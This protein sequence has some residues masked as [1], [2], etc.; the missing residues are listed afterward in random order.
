VSALTY[1][2]PCHAAAHGGAPQYRR[3]APA[4]RIVTQAGPGALLLAAWSSFAMACGYRPAA[5]VVGRRSLCVEGLAPHV[6]D[7]D[8]AAALEAGARQVLAGEGR[9]D[10]CEATLVLELV[11]L[12][13]V[14]EGLVS[15]R[16]D[17]LSRAARWTATA[18]GELHARGR[19]MSSEDLG[20]IRVGVTQAYA[21]TPAAQ[22]DA[23]SSARVEAARR[24]GEGLARRALGLP[25]PSDPR[26]LTLGDP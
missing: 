16:G 7:P 9:N 12:R 4:S 14:P 19:Q 17:V 3:G 26:P 10:A 21:S 13:S 11:E 5:D 1:C 24:A 15:R 8:A 2:R 6:S 18:H 25:A 23:S 20:L 22:L